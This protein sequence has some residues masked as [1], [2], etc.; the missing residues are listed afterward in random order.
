MLRN[1]WKQV[2]E[3]LRLC[4]WLLTGQFQKVET[5]SETHMSGTVVENGVT[6]AMT[7]EEVQRHIEEAKAM[8]KRGEAILDAYSRGKQ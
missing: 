8:L 6:R 1:I 2:T 7:E 4:Y 3:G 5:Y